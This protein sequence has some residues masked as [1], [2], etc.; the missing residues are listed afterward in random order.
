MAF[1]HSVKLWRAEVSRQSSIGPQAQ[2]AAHAA[3]S[4]TQFFTRQ[5]VQAAPPPSPSVGREPSQAMAVPDSDDAAPE[6][7]GASPESNDPG[8][9]ADDELLHP[10]EAAL[11]TAK[12]RANQEPNLIASILRP[13]Q[14]YATRHRV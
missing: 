8:E 3:D 4:A 7:E 11:V 14:R 1:G 13:P 2:S 9:P 10:C 6:S 12:P 5:A